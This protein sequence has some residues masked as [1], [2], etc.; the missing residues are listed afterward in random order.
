MARVLVKQGKGNGGVS[1]IKQGICV[2][3]WEGATR[4]SSRGK[5]S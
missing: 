2:W 5:G 4:C 3:L 1:G